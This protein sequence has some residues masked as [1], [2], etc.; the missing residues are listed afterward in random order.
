MS[1]FQKGIFWHTLASASYD[2][3]LINALAATKNN[4]SFFVNVLFDGP[5]TEKAVSSCFPNITN[6]SLQGCWVHMSG[7]SGVLCKPCRQILVS[8]SNETWPTSFQI[9]SFSVFSIPCHIV[10]DSVRFVNLSTN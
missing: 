6:L 2:L 1:K 3:A 8:T 7:V 9:F 5:V 10:C 4:V